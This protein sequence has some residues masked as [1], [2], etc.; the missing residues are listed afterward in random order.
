[1]LLFKVVH[2]RY[3]DR[4][5]EQN[6]NVCECVYVFPSYVGGNTSS[7]VKECDKY[8]EKIFLGGMLDTLHY[9]LLQSTFQVD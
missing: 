6:G 8:L 5:E 9:T 1:M 4:S 7:V 2:L 3:Q